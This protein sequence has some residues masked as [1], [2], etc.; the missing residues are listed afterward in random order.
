[1]MVTGLRVLFGLIVLLLLVNV[2]MLLIA[3]TNDGA[4]PV[5][6]FSQ[7]NLFFATNLD[8]FAGVVANTSGEIISHG[9]V[10][11]TIGIRG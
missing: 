7:W 11:G 3:I 2:L 6:I 8:E 1:M 9:T 5:Q 4:W 10:T